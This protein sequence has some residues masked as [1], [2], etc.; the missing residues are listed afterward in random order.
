MLPKMHDIRASKGRPSARKVLTAIASYG[1]A[2]S[3]LVIIVVAPPLEAAVTLFLLVPVLGAM[4]FLAA[5]HVRLIGEN[6]RLSHEGFTLDRKAHSD[7]LTGLMNRMAFRNALEET[8]RSKMRGEVALVFFDLNR[9]KPINDTLGHRIGDL[10]LIEVAQ[11]LKTHL[12]HALA[13]ARMGGDEFAA[14]LPVGGPR[15]PEECVLDIAEEFRSPKLLEGHLVQSGI[16]AGIAFG[17][18]ASSRDEDL[19]KHADLAMYEAKKSGVSGYRVFDDGMATDLS[20]KVNI[21]ANLR[22]AMTNGELS[23]YFQPIVD[24]RSGKLKCVE[25]LLRWKSPIMG[26]IPPDFVVKIAEESG[27][28]VELSNWVIE[29]AAAAARD[30]DDLPVG[31]NISPLHFRHNGFAAALADKMLD[32]GVTPDQIYIEITES[33]LIAHMDTARRTIEQLREM[34]VK[35]FLDDFGTGYSSLSYLHQLQFDG[36]KIDKSF[37]RD[38]GERNQATQIM[39]SVID[40]GHSLNLRVVAEG[41]E[42]DWQARLLQLLNCDL[43]QGFHFAT[44]MTLAE[45]KQFREKAAAAVE[46][47]PSQL[48]A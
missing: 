22:E 39:R 13:V 45:L 5:D 3:A 1:A 40:L 10:L 44:P 34:G 27:H 17:D 19:L 43:M 14:I 11:T 4:L 20:L 9:F 41:V 30:L 25:A 47:A 8:R 16:S 24:S 21:C 42:S 48:R 26:N 2:L 37:L 35:V 7:P 46:T 6:D 33:V 28:I 18:L 23:L 31:I 12:G 15:S 32:W 38:I 29:T 36:M